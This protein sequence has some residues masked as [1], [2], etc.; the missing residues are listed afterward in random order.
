MKYQMTLLLGLL[1]G[2]AIA[3]GFLFYNPLTGQT[4]LSPL[5]VSDRQQII[6]NYSAVSEDSIILTHDDESR[7]GIFSRV[8]PLLRYWQIRKRYPDKVLQLWEAPISQTEILVTELRDGRNESAGIGIKFSSRS[9][10]TRVLNGTALIDSAWYIYLPG[11]G[12]MLIEQSEN[13]WSFIREVVIPAHWS[14]GDS[15]R[16]TW[17]GTISDGPGAL[18]TGRVY[19]SSGL[20][21]GLESDVIETLTAKAYSADVGPI[22]MQ[23]QLTIEMISGDDD[24]GE[25]DE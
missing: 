9:E 16:G 12:T 1:T 25:P 2:A 14:S 10:R 22:S 20:F 15:W 23:G 4:S 8:H 18:G 19:G 7:A 21:V 11:Q 6:L 5:S 3:I 24:S 13:H 17:H